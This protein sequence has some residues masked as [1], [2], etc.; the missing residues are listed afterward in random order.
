MDYREQADKFLKDNGIGFAAKLGKDKCP[1]WCE[2][3]HIHGDH[4]RVTFYRLGDK[5]SR[6]TFSF[7]NSLND[8]EK[9]IT[10]TAYDAITALE[11]NEPG[12]FMEFCDEYGYDWDSIRAKAT[13]RAV[14]REWAKLQ[15]FFNP[16][17]IEAM[18]EIQ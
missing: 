1:I 5:R 12:D 13:W 15:A 3:K 8:K 7:W 9:G 17:E 18:Q 10:P 2:N 14:V 11:K 6:W 16:D 4:Y